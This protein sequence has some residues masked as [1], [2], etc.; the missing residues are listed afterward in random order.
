MPF[1]IENKA[2]KFNI[3]PAARD[4][5]TTS[6]RVSPSLFNPTQQSLVSSSEKKT[7]E[8][9]TKDKSN[10]NFEGSS[11]S[12]SELDRVFEKIHLRHKNFALAGIP[13]LTHH[14]DIRRADRLSELAVGYAEK[15]KSSANIRAELSHRLQVSGSLAPNGAVSFLNDTTKLS[16]EEVYQANF[17]QLET[18]TSNTAL[19]PTELWEVKR[20]WPWPSD[21]LPAISDVTIPGVPPMKVGTMNLLKQ[22]FDDNR[23]QTSQGLGGQLS[24]RYLQKEDE[25]VSTQA[26]LRPS[27]NIGR[28]AP[29]YRMKEAKQWQDSERMGKDWNLPTMRREAQN[30][31][32]AK[33]LNNKAIGLLGLNEVTSQHA[34]EIRKIAKDSAFSVVVTPSTRISRDLVDGSKNPDLQDN[35]VIL[36]DKSKYEIVADPIVSNYLDSRGRDNKHITT[37]ILMNKESGGVFGFTN[38]HADF[39]GIGKLGEHCAKIDVSSNIVVGDMNHSPKGVGLALDEHL[40]N[41]SVK[42]SNNTPGHVGFSKGKEGEVVAYDQVF[43]IGDGDVK[44]TDDI[45]SKHADY[46]LQ[47][48]AVFEKSMQAS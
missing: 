6:A 20:M 8:V 25:P 42:Y 11:A 38:T 35:G 13:D 5:D 19:T 22:G 9:E 32:I 16:M 34:Q 21:H 46:V 18:Y 44:E 41:K 28:K 26:L 39:G 24:S 31:Y 27:D 40:D 29:A 48:K 43:L 4:T 14:D 37:V 2:N 17:S 47:Y 7:A 45:H 33:Q 30:E 1:T 12:Q 3:Q 15:T 36:F 10:K 23:L